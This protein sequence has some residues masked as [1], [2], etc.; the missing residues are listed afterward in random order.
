MMIRLDKNRTEEIVIKCEYL[1]EIQIK[2]ILE[3]EIGIFVQD[4]KMVL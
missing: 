3:E 4:V 2:K 1:I